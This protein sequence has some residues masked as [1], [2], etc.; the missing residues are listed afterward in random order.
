[1]ILKKK[2]QN[3]I[4]S[5]TIK[6]ILFFIFSIYII[7]FVIDFS[8]H[9][10]KIISK[11]DTGFL[12]LIIYYYHNFVSYLNLF[13]TLSLMFSIIKIFCSLNSHNEL[14]ALN[15]GGLSIKRLSLPI[16][17][18]AS[19]ICV[20]SYLNYEYLTPNSNRY[21]EDF[22]N[23]YLKT[24]KKNQKNLINTIF[25]D[26]CTKII[27]QKID[28][29]NNNLFDV[30]WLKSKDDI[31]HIK[32]LNPKVTPVQGKFVDHFKRDHLNKIA[33]TESF[34][35]Y[36]FPEIHFDKMVTKSL[37][38]YN[39][40][41][42]STLFFQYKYNRFS[43]SA[44]KAY[45][46]SQLNYK[47]AMPLLNIIIAFALIPFCTR[48]SRSNHTLLISALS[49]FSFFGFYTLMDGA[50]ILAENNVISSFIIIWLPIILTLLFFSYKFFKGK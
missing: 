36:E 1:M 4:F 12:E 39:S 23:N 7:F 30:Y 48:F 31:W 50:L 6:F 41:P 33:K 13:L 29:S 34:T 17:I 42:I 20:I 18:L 8:I 43:S 21:I 5:D 19:A 24:K 15:M 3:W 38:P 14:I 37:Q 10:N 47:L 44:E 25:L 49:L 35:T 2:W 28:K 27:Y 45:I 26:N 46:L 40:R 22:K 16:F 9:G 32:Y 11:T